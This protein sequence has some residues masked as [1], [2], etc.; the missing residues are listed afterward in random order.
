M[1]IFSSDSDDIFSVLGETSGAATG[2]N[3]GGAIGSIIE[4]D[5]TNIGAEVDCDIGSSGGWDSIAI[6]DE[7]AFGVP[8]AGTLG[9]VGVRVWVGEVEHPIE[10][11]ARQAR[12]PGCGLNRSNVPII[13]SRGGGESRGVL[14]HISHV[15]DFTSVPVSG[16][17][18][19]GESRGATGSRSCI[20]AKHIAHIGSTT[21][22]PV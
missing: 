4:A 11:I 1:A 16:A 3:M 10:I 9:E 19:I 14:E 12:A 15:S 13:D 22:V 5:T 2:C 21:G 7:S 17:V 6:G 8:G 18:Y 20:T